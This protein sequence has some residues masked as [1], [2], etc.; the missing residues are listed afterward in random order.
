MVDMGQADRS[1]RS[2]QASDQDRDDVFERSRRN[3]VAHGLACERMG[4]KHFIEVPDDRVE[5]L[6]A[7]VRDIVQELAESE[8]APSKKP[9]GM[10]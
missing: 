10:R 3:R 9:P 2:V 5:E 6:N 7:L 4:F 1:L 8:R